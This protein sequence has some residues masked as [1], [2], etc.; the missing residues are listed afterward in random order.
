VSLEAHRRSDAWVVPEK[1]MEFIPYVA[2]KLLNCVNEPLVV[3]RDINLL[4]VCAGKARIARWALWGGLKPIALDRK[5]NTNF[6]VNT[7]TGLAITIASLL[8]VRPGGLVFIA[9]QCSSWIWM[10]R[11]STQRSSTNPY[12]NSTFKCVEEGNTLNCR[13]ALLCLLAFMSGVHYV[14]EQPASSLFFSTREWLGMAA[15]TTAMTRKMKM[16]DFGHVAAK[17]TILAGTA[18]WLTTVGV[19]VNPVGTKG[20]AP[21]SCEKRNTPKAKAKGKPGISPKA[22][23]K[24]K[25]SAARQKDMLAVH[26]STNGKTKVTGNREYLKKSQVYPAKFAAMVVQRGRTY[27]Y[28]LAGPA[29]RG[30]PTGRDVG[31]SPSWG[32]DLRHSRQTTYPHDSHGA[33]REARSTTGV[34]GI[35]CL[36]TVS[37]IWAPSRT[38]PHDP[39]GRRPS[40]SGPGE[41]VGITFCLAKVVKSHFPAAFG[42][43]EW[44]G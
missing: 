15:R 22:K 11:S 42:S 36:T 6:D 10:S 17:D 5:Y 3:V 18:P 39:A 38:Y 2:R 9:A 32:P 27:P 23:G 13:V 44:L 4:D 43:I 35:S 14:V 37:K 1:V 21:A 20:A 7:D 24:A 28:A 16:G 41:G 25:P 31:I 40:A 12:G 19:E 8:R 29:G 26:V 33:V 34:V 30:S